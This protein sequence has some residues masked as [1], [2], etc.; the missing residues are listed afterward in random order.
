MRAD[1][2]LL[3]QAAPPIPD[4]V[5]SENGET[6]VTDESVREGKQA[7]PVRADEPRVDPR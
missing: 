4:T 3:Y 1:A 6:V 5:E 7:F 2:W